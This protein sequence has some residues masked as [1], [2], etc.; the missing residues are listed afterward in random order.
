CPPCEP[1]L[2]SLG[3]FAPVFWVAATVGEG[4]PLGRALFARRAAGEAAASRLVP[5]RGRAAHEAPGGH[6]LARH[7]GLS[8]RQLARPP[9]GR[10]EFACRVVVI[11]PRR[12]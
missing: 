7:V 6:T 11:Q 10:S 9:D 3:L 4:V 5:G 2:E 1:A 12:G 8:A